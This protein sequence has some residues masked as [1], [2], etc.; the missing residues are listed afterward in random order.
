MNRI[1][2]ETHT[3]IPE[4]CHRVDRRNDLPQLC[5]PV[6]IF[7]FPF[8]R[9]FSSASMYCSLLIIIIL[10]VLLQKKSHYSTIFA[11]QR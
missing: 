11:V 10:N 3:G 1:N 8:H 7:T 5:M 4:V 9:L 6:I 2:A